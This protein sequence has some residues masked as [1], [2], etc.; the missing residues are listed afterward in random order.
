MKVLL[1]GGGGR[2][3][4]MA[5][6]LAHSPRLEKLYV[7]P[8]NP[9]IAHIAECVDIAADAIDELLSFATR[10]AIDLTVVGPEVP[11]TM[12][13]VDRFAEAGLK[14]FG[15]S[16]EAAR[17]EGSKAFSKEMMTRFGIPTAAAHA[18]TESAPA[19]TY[20]AD[21]TAPYVIKADGLAAG[22]GV[23][24]AETLE[25]A[26]HAVRE[27]LDERVFGAAGARV[28]IEE[29]LVGEEVSYLAFTDG[30]HIVPMV[31]AQDHKRIFDGDK[32]PNTGG[33]G[34]YS[35]APVMTP[36]LETAAFEQVLRPMIDGMRGMG[37]PYKGILYAGLMITP[38]GIKVLEFN[39]RFGDPETQPIL[40]RLDSDLLDICLASVNGTLDQTDVTW[41][42]DAA[43]CV[44]MASAGYPETSTRGCEI[45]GIEDAEGYDG[46]NVFHAGTARQNGK[47]VTAGGRVLGVTARSKTVR[48]AID[49]AY[50]AVARVR[51]EG[52]QFRRDIGARA[53]RRG[54][55]RK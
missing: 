48:K 53:I 19:L 47:L 41:S 24:I 31:S 43:V 20:L 45:T 52:M 54:G 38:K 49:L 37:V 27:I 22:K 36:E 21:M 30:E 28:V 1:V 11:L 2:E 46:V 5:W 13:I 29:F 6:K 9:G 26:Q 50:N 42:S 44:V 34:A 39:C 8:G 55:S 12:G 18:F 35:P 14:V 17:L 40:S 23:I 32:G 3:H 51:F 7:A 4:A 33:M 16:R 25:Q 10:E 15:P